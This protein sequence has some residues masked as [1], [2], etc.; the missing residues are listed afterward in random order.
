MD[1]FV[2]LVESTDVALPCPDALN[3]NV[4]GLGG[5]TFFTIKSLCSLR[6]NALCNAQ[7]DLG[8]SSDYASPLFKN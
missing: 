6:E 7:G 2:D 4:E 5:W 1:V 8:E 3:F